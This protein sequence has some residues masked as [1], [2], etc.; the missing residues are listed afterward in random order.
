MKLRH[1]SLLCSAILLASLSLSHSA[2]GATAADHKDDSP[3]L[4]EANRLAARCAYSDAEKLYVKCLA[5]QPQNASAHHMFGRM[6]ALETRYEE[7]LREYRLALKLKPNDARVMNDIG[8]A[9]SINSYQALGARFLNQAIKVDHNYPAA[10]NNIGVVLNGLSAYKQARDSFAKSLQIQPRNLKIKE[11][12][13]KAEAKIA[14]SVEFDFG[15]PLSWQDV[16]ESLKKVVEPQVETNPGDK[17]ATVPNS[18]GPRKKKPPAEKIIDDEDK[19]FLEKAQPLFLEL[20]T[21]GFV[22]LTL[23]GNGIVQVNDKSNSADEIGEIDLGANPKVEIMGDVTIDLTGP[24]ELEL[25][26]AKVISTNDDCIFSVNAEPGEL[27]CYAGHFKAINWQSVTASRTSS[28][29]DVDALNCQAVYGQDDSQVEAKDCAEVTLVGH[30]KGVLNNCKKVVVND[31]SSVVA[32]NCDDLVA[33]ANSRVKVSACG[34]VEKM[35]NAKV[36]NAD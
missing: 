21:R 6:L 35:D 9:L 7:A 11:L 23:S 27:A 19:D 24:G 33:L 15:G 3:V 26:K 8:V 20:K 16:P 36:E 4:A 5:A 29:V 17:I 32:R 2:L 28:Q 10:L 22:N 1:S 25:G 12:K 18:T 31:N 14:E 34:K 13:D 30:S